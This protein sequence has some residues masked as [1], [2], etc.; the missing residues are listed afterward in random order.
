[1]KDF[2]LDHYLML[3]QFKN[4]FTELSLEEEWARYTGELEQASTE[5]SGRENEVDNDFGCVCPVLDLPE[6]L[7]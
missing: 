2:A 7:T 1:M 6:R 4:K 5:G 3:E